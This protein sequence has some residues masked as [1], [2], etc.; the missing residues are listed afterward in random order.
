[1]SIYDRIAESGRNAGAGLNAY[2]QGRYNVEQDRLARED[3]QNQF[4]LERSDRQSQ[5]QRNAYVQDRDYNRQ[6]Q[7]DADKHWNDT[8]ELLKYAKPGQ[9]D[10][11]LKMRRNQAIEKNLPGAAQSPENFSD[12]GFD[13][14]QFKQG[15]DYGR[16]LIEGLDAQGNPVFLQA[17]QRGGVTPI[18]GFTPPKRETPEQKREAESA[19]RIAEAEAKAEIVPAAVKSKANDKLRS[20]SAIR[21]QLGKVQSVFNEIKGTLAAGGAGQTWVG[22][23]TTPEGGQKF[24]KAVAAL[25]PFIRQL[26]RTPGEGS[27][28]DYESKLAMMI[29]PDRTNYESVTQQQIDDLYD[30]VETI[31]SGYSGILGNPGGGGSNGGVIRRDASGRVMD[32]PAGWSIVPN[33]GN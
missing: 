27:M 29:N 8:I 31:E 30:M 22:A 6:L 33:A 3:R 18:S 2:V 32:S 4:D 15:G 14:S 1:M 28:S 16:D 7:A 21:Q 25:A 12:Y 26:T 5:I 17:N 9:E 24:D 11:I 23:L 19:A 10:K 13:F 20:I